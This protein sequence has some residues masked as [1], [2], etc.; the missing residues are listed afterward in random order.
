MSTSFYPH[1]YN[2]IFTNVPEVTFDQ[3]LRVDDG[4]IISWGCPQIVDT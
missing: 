2:G 4:E 3:F 1:D